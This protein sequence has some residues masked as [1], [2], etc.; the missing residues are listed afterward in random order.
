MFQVCVCVCSMQASDGETHTHA[1]VGGRRPVCEVF[2]RPQT[3]GRLSAGL[4]RQDFLRRHAEGT[5]LTRTHVTL[6]VY[7]CPIY[8]LTDHMS[9]PPLQFF[10]S[11]Y[12]HK[13]P[14]LCLDIC[15]VS[16]LRLH[17]L[18]ADFERDDLLYSI[19]GFKAKTIIIII[20]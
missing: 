18:S 12:G 4:H 20:T 9:L 11:L 3:V 6:N 10:L 16:S 8:I 1:A 19:K 7:M 2:S 13:L 15:H 14:V 5:S 17:Q